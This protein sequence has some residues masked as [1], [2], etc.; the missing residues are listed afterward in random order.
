[1]T[2]PRI[3]HNDYSVLSPPGI[4]EWEPY[5]PVSVVIAA[6]GH[7]D[8]LD[9]TL[10]ALA[11]QSYPGHLLE[12]I[13]VDDGTAPALRLG[14]IRPENTRLL[15]TEP[16]SRGRSNA[17][18]AGLEVAG[19]DVI[20]W[21]DAD[22][23]THHDEVEA[24]M[25]WHHL[26][27]YLVVM[28]YVRYVDEDW[29]APAEVHAAVSAGAGEKLFD[30]AASEPHQW[31]VELAERTDGMRTAK[32]TAYRVHITNAASVNAR[33]LR[34]AG[35][36]STDLVLGEDTEL[37]FRL[38]QHGAAFVLEPAARSWHLGRSMMMREGEAV[39]R[40]NRV[41]VPDRVPHMR[42]Q[43]THPRRQY[44]VP[45]L[46][47]VVEAAGA[48][49]ED[50]RATVD[51]VLASDLPDLRVTLVGPWESLAE[52]R[53]SPQHS[54]N[55]DLLLVSGLYRNDGRVRYVELAPRTAA[56]VP[57]RLVC[58]PGWVPGRETLRRLVA[59]AAEH[60]YGLV[61]VALDETDTVLSARLEHTGAFAR[62][63]LLAAPGETID[64]VVEQIA[65]TYWLDGATWGF[66][67][68]ADAP[69]LRLTGAD[70]AEA[71]RLKA[72]NQRLELRVAQLTEEVDR[73]RSETTS[74]L[75]PRRLFRPQRNLLT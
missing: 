36:L 64:D 23:V 30:L 25:R 71:T 70:R 65:G 55:L 5:L 29:P 46:D 1:M 49:Y 26:A 75:R 12:V 6:Y 50:V 2:S 73:L 39:S 62:A 27:D 68:A 58:P 41:F 61:S 42:W 54:A 34:E 72:A 44:L 4:G 17:R 40:Y 24:H 18:N 53:R 69:A 60:G 13:V 67:P 33:L 56:P 57:Y 35:P 20:H 28:G 14:E 63:R 15:R 66:L 31:V 52:D 37:G 32:D 9:L 11:A 38:A 51:G 21:L 10:A 43:R 45:Y 74:P 16:G 19:G 47:V 48:D 8:K 3:R 59:L 7:Q 22:M